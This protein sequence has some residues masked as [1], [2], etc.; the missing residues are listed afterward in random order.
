MFP[1]DETGVDRMALASCD[2]TSCS[3]NLVSICGLN[4]STVCRAILARF[5]LRINSS[6]LPENIDPQITSIQ[7]R[8]CVDR[9]LVSGK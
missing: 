4:I 2:T 5:S 6:V 3:E 7:P 8:G 9:R 1:G